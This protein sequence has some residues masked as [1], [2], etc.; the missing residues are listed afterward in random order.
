M[1]YSCKPFQ[2]NPDSSAET[3]NITDLIGWIPG[4]EEFLINSSFTHVKLPPI[5]FIP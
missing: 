4:E 2:H 5:S 1:F 3:S